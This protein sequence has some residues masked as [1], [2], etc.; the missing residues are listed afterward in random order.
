MKTTI[1]KNRRPSNEPMAILASFDTSITSSGGGGGRVNSGNG[2]HI[3]DSEQVAHP[4]H[5]PFY[6]S[7]TRVSHV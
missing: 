1:S 5:S 3:P 7:I 6:K 2:M 4:L